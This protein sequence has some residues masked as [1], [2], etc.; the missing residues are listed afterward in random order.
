MKTYFCLGHYSNWT[1]WNTQWLILIKRKDLYSSQTLLLLQ[2]WLMIV[3]IDINNCSSSSIIKANAEPQVQVNMTLAP[4]ARNTTGSNP[5]ISSADIFLASADEWRALK[6]VCSSSVCCSWLYKLA[7][8][9]L[10]T[11]KQSSSITEV[12][13]KNSTPAWVWV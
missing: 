4:F 5:D 9:S 12:S 2:W 1:Y 13:D 7:T 11:I 8:C 3:L 6:Y 10:Y